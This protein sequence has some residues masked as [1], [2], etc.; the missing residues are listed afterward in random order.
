VI[1][2]KAAGHKA[3]ATTLKF[4]GAKGRNTHRFKVRNLRPGH[5]TATVTA[6][7]TAGRAS[8]PATF[9]FTIVG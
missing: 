5:Y 6:R 1:K 7:D 8:K 9:T 2:P 4:A 3:K